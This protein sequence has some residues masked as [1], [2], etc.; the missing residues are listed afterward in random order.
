MKPRHV[1]SIVGIAIALVAM[2]SVFAGGFPAD[3]EGSLTY[4]LEDGI[5]VT[6]TDDLVGTVG[7]KVDGSAITL[8]NDGEA[9]WT[10]FDHSKP[11][12]TLEYRYKEYKG[13]TYHTE[14]DLVV[15]HP[16]YGRYDVTLDKDGEEYVG[17]VLIDGVVERHYEWE[18]DDVEY[19]VDASFRYSDYESYQSRIVD[20]HASNRDRTV[21]VNDCNGLVKGIADQIDSQ[22]EGMSEYDKANIILA[23]VQICFDY[24]P[25]VESGGAT[26]MSGDMYLT[27]YKDYS[28]YPVETL[29]HSAG[30]CEDTSILAAALFKAAG[31]NSGL[32]MVPGH[33]MAC[34][35]I[36]GDVSPNEAI[37]F[38]FYHAT[39]DGLEYYVCETTTSY[40]LDVGRG[41]SQDFGGQKIPYYMHRSEDRLYGMFIIPMDDVTSERTSDPIAGVD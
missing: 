41:S 39:V 5:K 16:G 33:A 11:S 36:E 27:G 25:H 32:L 9:D 24:P 17:T 4:E 40:A 18:Y 23:F 13:D 6:V 22:T 31:Y 8:K 28:M 15:D 37:G 38:G 2:A 21:F 1:L 12:S 19:S 10:V 35:A 26:L 30:D 29:F 34:V 7:C 14:G 20:R 3:R